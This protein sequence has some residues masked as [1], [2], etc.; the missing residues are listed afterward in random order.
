M[1]QRSRVHKVFSRAEKA[2][3]QGEI[4]EREHAHI[5]LSEYGTRDE[6]EAVEMIEAQ[7]AAIRSWP[8]KNHHHAT[9]PV[10]IACLFLVAVSVM[11]VLIVG[12]ASMTGAVIA[13]PPAPESNSTEHLGSTNERQNIGENGNV[14]GFIQRRDQVGS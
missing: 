3:S 4:T 9:I 7:I 1:R 11:G 12:K 13:T 5:L 14:E 8:R 10:M 2:L 6:R